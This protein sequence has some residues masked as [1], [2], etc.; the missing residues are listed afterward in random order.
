MLWCLIDVWL[1]DLLCSAAW[2]ITLLFLPFLHNLILLSGKYNE[3]K[4]S[5]HVVKY[6]MIG[7]AFARPSKQRKT[8]LSDP[9]VKTYQPKIPRCPLDD[10][11]R[12]RHHTARLL[13]RVRGVQYD[14]DT[15]VGIHLKAWFLMYL[16]AHFVW[17]LVDWLSF[18][19]VTVMSVLSAGWCAIVG[20][21]EKIWGT[22]VRRTL[23]VR[24]W[25]ARDV[26][27]A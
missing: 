19:R 13:Q 8:E 27:P 3:I 17:Q 24:Y 7:K 20:S 15:C 11:L 21:A 23:I 14:L 26:R 12:L 18:D 9:L 2:S 10:E 6:Q 22:L 1:L 4:I 16:T 25:G 5:C